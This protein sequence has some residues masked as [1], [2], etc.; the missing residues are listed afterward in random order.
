MSAE[1]IKVS[2]K[3]LRDNDVDVKFKLTAAW[4]SFMFIYIYVDYFH[5]YMPGSIMDII[6][7]KVFTFDISDIFLMIAMFF[8]AI[9]AL[10][11]LLS[12]VLPAGVNRRINMIVAIMYIPYMLFNLAG[13]AWLHMIFGALVE[14]VL[15]LLIIRLS[16][17]WPTKESGSAALSEKKRV[18]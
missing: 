13:E 2:Q 8:V 6:S 3:E 12:L 4:T 5:L 16:W 10:M 11:I 15:L 1:S 9:P 17:K 14:V 18:Y 7:G